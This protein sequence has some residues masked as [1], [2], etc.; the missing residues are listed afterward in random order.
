[1]IEK[2]GLLSGGYEKVVRNKRYIFWFWLLNL[3]LAEF[4]VAAFRN[5]AHAILDDSLYSGGLVRGFNLGVF[6]EMLARLLLKAART[7]TAREETDD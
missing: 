1:M 7:S 3:T 5:Q 4:G 2:K 6:I